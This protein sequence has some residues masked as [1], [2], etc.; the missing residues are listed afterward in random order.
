MD[1]RSANLEYRRLNQAPTSVKHH[2]TVQGDIEMVSVP[3]CLEKVTPDER[4]CTDVNGD[5]HQNEKE[6]SKP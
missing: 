4:Q 5:D 2:E 6:A 3:E 1:Y